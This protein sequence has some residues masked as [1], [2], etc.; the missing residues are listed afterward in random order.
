MSAPSHGFSERSLICIARV[1]R[2]E[3]VHALS[4]AFVDEALAV[5]HEYVFTPETQTHDEVCA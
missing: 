2:F 1:S 4:P 3:F 5:A